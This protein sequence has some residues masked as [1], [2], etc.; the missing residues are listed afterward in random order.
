MLFH[1]ILLEGMKGCVAQV[2]HDL[3]R[4]IILTLSFMDV[5]SKMDSILIW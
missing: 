3:I 5:T 1:N 4:T 2:L